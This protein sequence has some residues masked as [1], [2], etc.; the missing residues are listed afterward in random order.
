MQF[1]LD[2]NIQ[3]MP[4]NDTNFDS[5][6]KLVWNTNNLKDGDHQLY[7]YVTSLQ[8][9]GSIAVDYLEYVVPSLHLVTKVVFQREFCFQD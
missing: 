9:N 3:S 7:V 4:L 2:G 1:R 6:P 5:G 8:Q